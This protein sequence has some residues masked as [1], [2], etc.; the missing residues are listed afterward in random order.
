MNIGI[1]TTWFERGAAYV[2]KAYE[3][4][5]EKEHNVFIYARG[6]EKYGKGDPNWDRPNVTFSPFWASYFFPGHD[7][8]SR[9]HLYKWIKKNDIHVLFFNE[10]H[11]ISLVKEFS[12]YGLVTG[13]YIDYYKKN[14][15]QEF[16]IY[17]F[18]VCNTKR[19]YSVFD[20]H[21]KC[22][23]IQWGTDTSL[24]KPFDTPI[25]KDAVTFFHSAGY[26]G[27]NGRKGTGILVRAFQDIKG[28]AKLVIHSQVPVQK[29]GREVE[30]II[31]KDKRIIF[32]EK[33]VSAPGLYH[34]GDIYVYPTKL[35]GIGLSV[36][37]ALSCG[38]P[39]ITTDSAPMNEF[40]REGLNG[41]LVCVEK[42][43]TRQDGYYWQET[44][45]D[46]ANLT[47][48]MQ[49]YMNCPEAVSVQK[50]NARAFAV[51]NLDWEKNSQPLNE[52]VNQF[53]N[54]GKLKKNVFLFLPKMFIQDILRLG[55]LGAHK[56]L[57]PCKFFWDSIR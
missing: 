38:L 21:P 3:K 17:D 37:E 30:K 28:D 40:V 2:S 55:A 51:E 29:Y 41:S 22:L 36:P 54:S 26:G 1:I 14:T 4:T 34:L 20:W 49:Y 12:G 16:E 43:Q 7:G 50:T 10:Q 6:G 42:R 19:H 25:S 11:G 13:A 18:L 35:E 56:I 9:L 45:P 32:I 46:Q 52:F 8:M 15:V 44:I 5:F 53:R 39:V 47:K 31:K 57:K 24:F 23:F 27:V 33:T 48:K